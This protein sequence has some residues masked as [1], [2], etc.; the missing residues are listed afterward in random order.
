[1][2]L[3]TLEGRNTDLQDI[4]YQLSGGLAGLKKTI[5]KKAKKVKKTVKKN[6]HPVSIYANVADKLVNSKYA[7]KSAK[8]LSPILNKISDTTNNM[9]MS[10][11]KQYASG[12]ISEKIANSGYAETFNEAKNEYNTAKGEYEAVKDQYGNII[13]SVSSSPKYDTTEYEATPTGL[14]PLVKKAGTPTADTDD[15]KMM[16]IAGAGV[17]V[18]ALMFFMKK[19]K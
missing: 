18:L 6:S 15:N 13:P 9:S 11:A 17:A 19:K 3:I 8:K 10:V 12:I 2:K 4:Q 1:M 16:Y 7:P 14:T 5:K